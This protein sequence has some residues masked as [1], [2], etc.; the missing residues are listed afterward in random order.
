MMRFHHVGLLVDDLEF[1]L[2]N[3]RI[4]FGNENIS[5]IFKVTSQKVKVCFVKVGD[6]SHIELVQPD[7]DGSP[8]SNLLKKRVSYYHAGYCVSNIFDAIQKLE[9]LNYKALEVFESEAFNG[10]K[11]VFLFTPEAHLIE[12]I[13]E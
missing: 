3:Y 1:S 2:N 13:E 5:D 9:E 4:L 7:G 8:V 6:N 11:C 10:R 12:L